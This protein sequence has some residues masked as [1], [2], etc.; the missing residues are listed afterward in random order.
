MPSFDIAG[1]R[2][3]LRSF[4]NRN[5]ARRPDTELPF[6][7]KDTLASQGILLDTCVYID[8][9]QGKLPADIEQF[10]GKRHLNHSS[11][12][13]QELAHSMGALD[14]ADPRTPR[15]Q[16]I[17]SDTIGAMT[18][19]RTSV[20]D[21]EILGRAAILNGVICRLQHY[22]DDQKRKC[23]QDC[24]LYLQGLKNGF[25]ILSRNVKDFD[26]CLQLVPQGRV[27]FYRV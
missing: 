6:F 18:D 8:Q 7:D 4:P 9:M 25:V 20:P 15:V 24:T 10:L 17:I 11:V 26:M 12:A 3:W 22:S 16:K 27:I 2:R 21:V 14:P 1:A 19:H 5:I 23:L 13:I